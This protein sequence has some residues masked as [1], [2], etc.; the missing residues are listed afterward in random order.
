MVEIF[1]HQVTRGGQGGPACLI[2]GGPAGHSASL[3]IQIGGIMQ[4]SAFVIGGQGTMASGGGG[5]GHQLAQV[6]PSLSSIENI[7]VFM[8]ASD[9]LSLGSTYMLMGCTWVVGD[10]LLLQLLP[11]L[12]LEV[13]HMPSCR[14]H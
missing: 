9:I 6:T 12:P 2:A 13:E 8:K 5:I 14:H 3:G 11:S 4:P 1:S 10:R 7:K